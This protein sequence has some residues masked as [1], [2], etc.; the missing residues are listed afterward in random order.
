MNAQEVSMVLTPLA[1]VIAGTVAIV[2]GLRHRARTLELLHRERMAMIERGLVPAQPAPGAAEF[3]P[4][5]RSAGTRSRSFSL[6]IVIVGLGLAL[7]VL[8]GVAGDDPATAIGVGG[9][10]AIVGA[11][12]IVRALLAQGAAR[13]G[14]D[15]LPY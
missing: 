14:S 15:G 10:I 4:A 13:P 8:I 3:A 6:G 2:A 5:V 12:F 9:A 7:M 11:S 1:L